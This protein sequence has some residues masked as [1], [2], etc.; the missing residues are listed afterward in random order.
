MFRNIL[1]NST[2]LII[3]QGVVK[4]ITFF[5]TIYLAKNFGVDNFGLYTIA[6]SYYALFT[7]FADFGISRF[8]TR[9]IA[10]NSKNL[11]PLLSNVIFLRFFGMLFIF[12]IFAFAFYLLDPQKLRVSLILIIFLAIFPQVIAMSFDNVLVALKKFSLSSIAYTILNLVIVFVGYF[13]VNNNYG[14]TGAVIAILIGQTINAVVL[15]FFIFRQKINITSKIDYKILK[16]IVLNSLPYGILMVVGF[17][18]FRI[19]SL[20]LAYFKGSYDVGI[21][22]AAYR[23]LE[24]VV[25]IPSSL[26]TVLF[27]IVA[28]LFE[29][30]ISKIKPIYSKSILILGFLGTVIAMLYVFI[31]PSFINS[32]L[33]NYKP[34]IDAL[35]VL[36]LSIPFIFIHI[37]SVQIVLSTEKYLKPALKIFLTIMAVNILMC[38]LFIPKFGFMGAAWITLVGEILTSLVFLIF[39]KS[40]VFKEV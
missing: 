20:I 1:K 37:P 40:R 29:T 25:F 2:Y 38:L 17:I 28:N 16:S 18:S 31:L 22:G 9:E 14:P 27:P 23:F 11:Q 7:A 33:P 13:L 30:D 5:F 34:S 39:L 3:A 35:R 15:M 4:I 19:D 26:A 8:I 32:F 10:R 12:T 6:L 36:A 21:Y 24:A